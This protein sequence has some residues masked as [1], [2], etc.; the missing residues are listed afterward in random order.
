MPNPKPQL[1]AFP[2]AYMDPLTLP[3]PPSTGAR[4]GEEKKKEKLHFLWFGFD[5]LGVVSA[6]DGELF[7]LQH[8]A[9]D[10]AA[11]V[12]EPI[13]CAAGDLLGIIPM[14]VLSENSSGWPS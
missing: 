10:G 2:K 6:D 3:S 13:D 11:F 4:V 9:G 1:A 8:R 5:F 7:H 14:L 12:A